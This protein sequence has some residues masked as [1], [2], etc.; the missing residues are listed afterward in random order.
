MAKVTP[1]GK[2]KSLNRMTPCI[3]QALVQIV[4]GLERHHNVILRESF[5]NRAPEDERASQISVSVFQL[6]VN[7]E[8]LVAHIVRRG[9]Q[10]RYVDARP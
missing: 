6:P 3:D 2:G 8:H 5:D 4:G 7:D 1:F 10:V 9:I